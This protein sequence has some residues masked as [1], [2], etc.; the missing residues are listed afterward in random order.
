MNYCKKC[1]TFA[2]EE[3]YCPGCGADILVQTGQRTEEESQQKRQSKE[4]ESKAFD[5]TVN[6]Q[7]YGQ[8]A[9]AYANQGTSEYQNAYGYGNQGNQNA[10]GYQNAYDGYGNYYS[11][12]GGYGNPY[13][14]QVYQQPQP[15]YSYTGFY[16]RYGNDGM[17]TAA[18]VLM[19][20]CTIILAL[21][22]FGVGLAWG[23]PMT[24]H[25]NKIRNGEAPNTVGFGIC[26]LLF[27]SLIS[28][29]LLLIAPKDL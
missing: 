4:A 20:I 5:D 19:I 26:C 3:E 28:G 1:G 17:F 8:N 29:I 9:G 6:R 11:N 12:Q 15:T 25:T 14:N 24:I 7:E 2:G 18:F 16:P 22:T 21:C 27:V 10:G 23:I 13:Q